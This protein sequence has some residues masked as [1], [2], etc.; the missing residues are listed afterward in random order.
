MAGHANA[1]RLGISG[2]LTCLALMVSGCAAPAPDPEPAAVNQVDDLVRHSARL[3][4]VLVD[5]T[6]LAR[7]DTVRSGLSDAF[8]G[9]NALADTERI[10]L[11]APELQVSRGSARAAARPADL[12]AL[13]YLGAELGTLAMP[14]LVRDAFSAVGE[15]HGADL[16]EVAQDADGEPV[17]NSDGTPRMRV[18]STYAGGLL[19]VE[20]D[21][22]QFTSADGQSTSI[23]IDTTADVWGCPDPDGRYSGTITLQTTITH[24]GTAGLNSGSFAQTVELA[25]TVGDDA[26]IAEREFAYR[27]ALRGGEAAEGLYVEASGSFAPS[28]DAAHWSGTA[29]IDRASQSVSGDQRETFLESS[30]RVA[31]A[32]EHLIARE[33]ETFLRSGA[34]VTVVTAPG[35]GALSSPH[36]SLEVTVTGRS[37]TDGDEI[38][39][40]TAS[41]SLR[42]GGHGV[43]PDGQ[44]QPLPALVVYTGPDAEEEGVVS[45]ELVSRRGIGRSDVTYRVGQGWLLDYTWEGVRYHAVKCGDLAGSW[46]L[47]RVGVPEGNGG[48][49]DAVITFDIEPMALLG[50][51]T[52]QGTLSFG[53]DVITATYGGEVII[54]RQ[55]DGTAVLQLRATSG[56]VEIRG[57]PS[58]ATGIRQEPPMPLVP[59]SDAECTG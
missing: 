35:P 17:L 50:Y 28:A 44:K 41:A 26:M 33:V 58:S 29:S 37:A 10:R 21:F 18:V 42:S 48:S 1:R 11:F 57:V 20:G 8:A 24:T 53:S 13:G 31:E 6:G 9:L 43:D 49:L 5:T 12:A 56:T 3:A 14:G 38:S 55:D 52:E 15:G 45:Y 7:D 2:G 16:D 34:C 51:F 23:D 19:R 32:T 39:T 30:H 59:T 25:G 54:E 40:G 4:D 27:S 46:I 22:R 47:T 36:Q